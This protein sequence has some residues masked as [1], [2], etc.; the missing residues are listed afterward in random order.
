MSFHMSTI[1]KNNKSCNFKQASFITLLFHLEFTEGNTCGCSEWC[2]NRNI[3]YGVCGDGHT[4]ICRMQPITK[5][6]IGKNNYII[7]NKKLMLVMC[8]ILGNKCT[9]DSWCQKQG[10][11]NGGICGDGY[12]CICSK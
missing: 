12:T 2:H 1:C 5:D 4:C 8:V 7:M 3:S 9:C 10:H 11:Q 6:I